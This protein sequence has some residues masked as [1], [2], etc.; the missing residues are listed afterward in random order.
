[1]KRT[2][3]IILSLVML[4][5]VL[6]LTVSAAEVDNVESGA[7]IYVSAT[8]ND[9]HGQKYVAVTWDKVPGADSYVVSLY[10][11]NPRGLWDFSAFGYT[12]QQTINAEDS[13]RCVFGYA[14]MSRFSK[15]G[16]NYQVRIKAIREPQGDEINSTLIASGKTD[17]F[18]TGLAFLTKPERVNLDSSGTVTWT[19]STETYWYDVTLKKENGDKIIEKTVDDPRND[20]IYDFAPYVEEEGNYY[21]VVRPMT[22]NDMNKYDYRYRNLAD[23]DG[24]RSDIVFAN[25]GVTG[26]QG[27]TWDGYTLKWTDYPT[28]DHYQI[29]KY[30]YNESTLSFDK[31]ESGVISTNQYDFES[32]FNRGGTGIYRIKVNALRVKKG[33]EYVII[34]DDTYS[35]I[36]KYTKKYPISYLG[37]GGYGNVDTIEVDEFTKYTLPENIYFTPPE[38]KEFDKWQNRF[39]GEYYKPGDVLIITSQVTFIPIWK[40]SKNVTVSFNS[41]G[42][43][44]T[45]NPVSVNKGS[46]YKLPECGFTHPNG[47]QFK[48]WKIGSYVYNPGDTVAINSDTT[49]Y[50]QW[51][52]KYTITYDRNGGTGT[53]AA[54]TY[55]EGDKYVIPACRFTPPSNM[56]FGGWLVDG[57]PD[58][59]GDYWNVYSDHVLKPQWIPSSGVAERVDVSVTPP[60]AGEKPSYDVTVYGSGN[61]I[62]GNE[63]PVSGSPGVYTQ[64]KGVLWRDMT[65]RKNHRSNVAF[66][67]GHEYRVSVDLKSLG[68]TN[69]NFEDDS[70]PI[71]Q[72]YINGSAAEI[73]PAAMDNNICTAMYTF[74]GSSGSTVSGTETS[75]LSDSET[76]TV[77]LLQ[78]GSVK[79]S[80]TT[81]G[82]TASY[83]IPNVANGAYT[84]RVSKKNHVT[85]DYAITVSGDTTQ[86]VKI[87]PLGDINGDGQVNNFDF[88]RV[89]SH[90]RGKST[91]TD[92]EFLCGDINNDGNINN[93][94][95]GRINSHARGKSSLWT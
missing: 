5:S 12:S 65:T 37:N 64:Y 68:G 54:E 61:V 33:N 15:G 22:G 75:F 13:C 2:L 25:R 62:T 67:D 51:K 92:Y 83:S 45:M 70:K 49:V 20:C 41:N 84:L 24:T 79:Y 56:I 87:H 52:G 63:V 80:A 74:S 23:D 21:A 93:F 35:P 26:I 91:L 76:V 86:V 29:E 6:P 32:E 47:N 46:Y 48:N 10:N 11:D 19:R 72:I 55:N 53:M 9:W 36:V 82:K 60:K 4:F 58:S 57:K 59:V 69:F 16:K 3:A 78:S 1:M 8:V 34:S 89:N 85:R 17:A 40:D 31:G 28:A 7:D 81:K 44:G 27:L 73:Q 88:G 94:D 39:T 18:Q 30:K 71:T 66:V 43:S 14:I 50:A 90:A 95:A 38:G 42:G 77:Q